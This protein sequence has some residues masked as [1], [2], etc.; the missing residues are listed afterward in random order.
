MSDHWT[1]I[2]VH[3]LASLVFPAVTAAV[4]VGPSVPVTSSWR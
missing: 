3:L 4:A 1:N 2:N